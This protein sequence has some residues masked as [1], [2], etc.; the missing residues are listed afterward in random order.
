MT[1]ITQTLKPSSANYW[2]G[3]AFTA[4]FTV[5]LIAFQLLRNIDRPFIW[6]VLL[7][8]V[9]ASTA[10][11]ALFFARARIL[12][13]E[14]GIGKQ[15][16]VGIRWIP[17]AEIDR[18]LLVRGFKSFGELPSTELFLFA[19]GGRKLLRLSGRLWTEADMITL[20][21]ATGATQGLIPGPASAKD[22]RA[23][24][25]TAIA[26]AERHPFLAAFAI[27]AVLIVAIV[28]FAIVLSR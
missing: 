16:I 28:P 6:I 17:F 3:T 14:S 22:V 24:E 9:V 12:I 26:W 7:I 21:T 18:A 23:V 4:L 27:T 2:K 15:R 13:Q 8:T 1:T 19:A 25:P 20:A 5:P 10:G 11:V